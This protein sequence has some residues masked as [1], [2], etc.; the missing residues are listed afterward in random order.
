MKRA[1][2]LILLI[3][4]TAHADEPLTNDDIVTLLKAGVPP[5]VIVTKIR[6]SPTHF[7]VS[8]DAIVH[9]T[10][11]SVPETV[12][13]AMLQAAAP[14]TS[15]ASPSAATPNLSNPDLL[16]WKNMCQKEGW[17]D[18]IC[19][20][21]TSFIELQRVYFYLPGKRL[22][23]V[24]GELRISHDQIQERRGAEIGL[25]LNWSDISSFCT[26]FGPM[27]NLF[28]VHAK[29]GD[30]Q[31]DVG[32]AEKDLSAFLRRIF[33]TARPEHCE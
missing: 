33:L 24:Q 5:S 7:D 29:Q 13:Q 25:L 10:K 3:A 27:R 32:G 20:P 1:L 8:T 19:R 6:T 2:L 30:F 26:E 17:P 23:Q 28:I 15:T 11:N 31:W 14:S 12:L 9:L 22:P 4:T 16:S 21:D 18:R